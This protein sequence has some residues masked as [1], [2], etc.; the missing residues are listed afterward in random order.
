MSATPAQPV[1]CYGVIDI[2]SSAIRLEVAERRADGSWRRLESAQ[3]PAPLGRDVFRDG[4]IGRDT[5]IRSIRILQG[6][7]EL[8]APYEITRLRAVGTSALREAANREVFLDRIRVR[9]G[10]EVEIIEGIE[11]NYLTYLA[12]RDALKGHR[13]GWSRTNS[14]IIEVGAGSTEM[15]VLRRGRIVAAHTL[16]LGS[17]RI[18]EELQ[19]AAGTTRRLERLLDERVDSTLEALSPEV[20]LGAVKLFIAVGG[21]ARLAAR[22]EGEQAAETY[23]ALTRPAFRRFIREL[24]GVSVD[25]LVRRYAITHDEAEMLLP[26]LLINRLFLKRT[27]ATRLVVPTVSIREGVLLGCAE[28]SEPLRHEDLYR[29][30][31]AS[32]MSLA[33]KFHTDERHARHVTDLALALYDAL[34]EDH[35]LEPKHRLLLEVAG[36][37]HDIGTY[38]GFSSH[39]KHGQY[40]IRA[41]E[42]FGLHHEDLELVATVVRYHRKATPQNSHPEFVLLDQNDRMAVLKLGAILRVADAMDRGHQERVRDFQLERTDEEL[43]VRARTSGDISLEQIGI[44]DKA[45]M[46]E[47][48]FGLRVVL[49]PAA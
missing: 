8:L 29:Q 16:R 9:T 19:L 44:R 46:F 20:S 2:G 49:V 33:R 15:M 32:T 7:R 6:F 38:I 12:V 3:K 37:L 41:S 5:M 42:I 35:A 31:I 23:W 4:R 48:V 47:E 21:D 25:E 30:M 28:P 13:V 27:A 14:L 10:I 40:I 45:D 11:A 34:A 36:L 26:A 43:I 24:D 1:P 18:E 22:Q 39:H 17:A